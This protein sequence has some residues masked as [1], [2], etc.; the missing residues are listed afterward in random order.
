LVEAYPDAIEFREEKLNFVGANGRRPKKTNR[1]INRW[2]KRIL[3]DSIERHVSASGARREFV[4]AAYTSQA[5]P[6]CF[7]TKKSNRK[8]EAFR[9]PHCGYRGHADAVAGSNVLHWGSDG[10]IMLFTPREDV[11]KYLLEKHAIWRETAGTDARC[12]SWGCGSGLSA[13][14]PAGSGDDVAA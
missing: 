13:V 6:R 5:C 10:T 1:K 14:G 4:P 9:C 7:W 12:A 8:E 3:S 2:M 11:K